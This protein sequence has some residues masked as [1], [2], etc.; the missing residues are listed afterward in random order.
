MLRRDS[1]TSRLPHD[2]GWRDGLAHLRCAVKVSPSNLSAIV[3]SHSVILAETQ[4]PHFDFE[5]RF[6]STAYRPF[7]VLGTTAQGVQ[8]PIAPGGSS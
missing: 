4:L 7:Q 3:P 8:Q 2:G 5:R 1:G 6:R